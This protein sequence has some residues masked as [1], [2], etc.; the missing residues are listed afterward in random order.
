MAFSK[1][2]T[3]RGVAAGYIRPVA[4]RMDDNTR[5]L[6]V[7]FDLFIDRAHSDRCKPGAANR[8]RPLVETIAKLRVYGDSYETAFGSEARK[9][10]AEAGVDVVAMI[11]DA[12][13]TISRARRAT[14]HDD[15]EA[16]VISDFGADVF[17]DAANV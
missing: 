16:H 14:G 12:A 1:S 11:Y 3:A 4:W 2:L 15:P 9:A 10:A 8:D 17:A 13:K 7:L 6:S 5:E